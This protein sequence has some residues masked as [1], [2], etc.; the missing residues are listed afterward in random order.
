MSEVDFD[1]L[2]D[3]VASAVALPADE[4]VASPSLV[5]ALPRAANDNELAAWPLLPFPEN[6]YATF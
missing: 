2:L 6:W 4:L 1:L 5:P 3:V